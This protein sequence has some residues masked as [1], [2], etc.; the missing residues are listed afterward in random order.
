M[1]GLLV[2][3]VGTVA[4]G[5]MARMLSRLKKKVFAV[6]FCHLNFPLCYHHYALD[7]MW[8]KPQEYLLIL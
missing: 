5:T 4:D 6:A 8:E 1:A 3:T 2:I 7:V